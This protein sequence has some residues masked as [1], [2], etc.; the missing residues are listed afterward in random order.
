MTDL[1]SLILLAGDGGTGRVSFHREKYVLKGGPDGGAGGAGGSIVLRGTKSFST[2]KPYAG[3][4]EF[5][6]EDGIPGGSRKKYGAK[7]DD[8]VLEVPIG[9]EIWA[10]AENEIAR[11][12]RMI[13]GISETWKKDDVL[14][15]KY[16]LEKEGQ[17]PPAREEDAWLTALEGTV[18][19]TEPEELLKDAYQNPEKVL[20]GTITEHGQEV[21]ICQGGFGGRGNV[22]FKG[23]ANTTPLEAE[24]GATGEKRL[25][26]LEL[27]LLADVGLVG[28]PNAGKSTLLSRLTKARPKIANYPFTTLEPNLGV[29]DADEKDRERNEVV[30]ADIPG[31]IEGA[32]QGKGLG[33]E[34]LRHIENTSMLLFVLA[35]DEAVVFD[36]EVSIEAKAQR[37]LEQFIS[38]KKEL[39]HYGPLLIKKPYQVSV[40]K[41]DLYS[42]ELQEAITG[43]FTKEGEDVLLFSGVTGDGL[44][45]LRKAVFNMVAKNESVDSGDNNGQPPTLN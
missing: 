24:Y 7:S 44:P 13:K 41:S 42:M 29:L 34:F 11:K 27:K 35:L 25:V 16:Y 32:S 30:L 39:Q 22:A 31:L 15:E 6:A 12:R 43:I 3:K 2:L 9:T 8:V 18:L 40:N 21:I 28:F 45:S 19:T 17:K 37:L 5:V 20:V 36:D 26:V 14:R 38:L 4:V 10:V 23:P 1:V 33:F